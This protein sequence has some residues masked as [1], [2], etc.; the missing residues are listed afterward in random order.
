MDLRL[1]HFEQ[2]LTPME[3]LMVGAVA[4]ALRFCDDFY[5]AD[6]YLTERKLD[7]RNFFGER[8]LNGGG[9]KGYL[10]RSH[11]T[12]MKRWIIEVPI[13]SLSACIL[14]E[15]LGKSHSCILAPPRREVSAGCRRNSFSWWG[16]SLTSLTGEYDIYNRHVHVHISSPANTSVTRHRFRAIR[17][18]HFREVSTFSRAIPPISPDSHGRG[19]RFDACYAHTSC[20]VH[21]RLR[22][23]YTLE[24][25]DSS[26][27]GVDC[28]RGIS[29][30]CG[31][32]NTRIPADPPLISSSPRSSTRRVNHLRPRR[33]IR[34]H[35][36]PNDELYVPR[37]RGPG[38]SLFDLKQK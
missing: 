22:F 30:F 24:C 27:S 2:K 33:Q 37:F 25:R 38:A 8:I 35:T 29:R 5:Q 7:D 6:T 26:G 34:G 23:T 15:S 4:A 10:P 12:I 17:R 31:T 16:T 28:S 36:R 1:K 14:R 32:H 18:S 3:Q 20:G 19:N 11:R 21:P 9:G 13:Y